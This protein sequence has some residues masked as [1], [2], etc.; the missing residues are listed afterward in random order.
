MDPPIAGSPGTFRPLLGSAC[1]GNTR[2]VTRNLVTNLG[3]VK[4]GRIHA[5]PV[6][7]AVALP[8]CYREATG[9]PW[10]KG[11][12]VEIAKG[13]ALVATANPALRDGDRVHLRISLVTSD[14]DFKSE[15]RATGRVMR[16][17]PSRFTGDVSV[18]AISFDRS[19]LVARSDAAWRWIAQQGEEGH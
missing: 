5:G 11:K 19:S 8:V 15:I 17:M 14:A 7:Y 4:H 10:R 1:L 16:V 18:M 13:G 3:H 6:R 2:L 12:T 9:R